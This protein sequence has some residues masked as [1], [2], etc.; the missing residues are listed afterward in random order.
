MCF[1]ENEAPG[2]QRPSGGG[3]RVGGNGYEDGKSQPDSLGQQL[4]RLDDWIC[5]QIC[6]MG[7]PGCRHPMLFLLLRQLT[8]GFLVTL[9]EYC[10][11][12]LSLLS[13]VYSH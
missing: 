8:D 4:Y 2:A 7:M 12:T 3:I 13:T 6:T 5:S 10:V 9:C 1:W 11:S